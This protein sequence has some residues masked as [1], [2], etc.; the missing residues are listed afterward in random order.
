MV[1]AR[2]VVSGRVQGVSYRAFTVREA[3]RHGVSGWVRNTDQ[4]EVEAVFEGPRH[5]VEDLVRWCWDGSPYAKVV[6]VQVAWEEPEGEQDFV[7][8][9]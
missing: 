3:V 7:V 4:G 6:G 1:R 8:R 2:V 9:Y 5:A